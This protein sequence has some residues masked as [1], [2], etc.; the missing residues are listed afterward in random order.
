MD[1]KFKPGT[2]SMGFWFQNNQYFEKSPQVKQ[3]WLLISC[4]GILLQ[5]QFGAQFIFKY[6]I[7]IIVA[8]GQF[9]GDKSE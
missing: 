1:Q 5:M 8:P 4:I 6:F 2:S 3:Y 7:Q 9:F